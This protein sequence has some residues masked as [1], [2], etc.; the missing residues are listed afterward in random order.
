MT[1]KTLILFGVVFLLGL[2][3]VLV[4]KPFRHRFDTGEGSL[5]YPDLKEE[6]IAAIEIEYLANGTRFEKDPAGKWLVQLKETELQKQVGAQEK[7]PAKEINHKKLPADGDKVQEVIDTLVELEKGPPVTDNP[8][9]QGLLELT[10]ASL[11]VTA[12]DAEGKDLAKLYVGKQGPDIFSTFVRDGGD[13]TI[14]LV[15][16]HLPGIFNRP[17][18][19]WV[20]KEEDKKE[21]AEQ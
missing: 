10:E 13:N 8:E 6:E 20:E 1:K 9:K 12:F 11:H 15:D 19:E 14:H 16:K 4:E 5:F 17:I 2:V 21:T 18:E 7:K 3:V